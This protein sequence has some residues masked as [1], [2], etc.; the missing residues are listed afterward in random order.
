MNSIK[1]LFKETN[2]GDRFLIQEVMVQIEIFW[3][4]LVKLPNGYRIY[5]LW[6]KPH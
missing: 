5:N 1:K 6:T 4:Q 3:F 2:E